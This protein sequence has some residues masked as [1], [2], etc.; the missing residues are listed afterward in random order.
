MHALETIAVHSGDDLRA[1]VRRA[2]EHYGHG[3]AQIEEQLAEMATPLYT[4]RPHA[5]LAQRNMVTM[6]RL[7]VDVSALTTEPSCVRSWYP[8]PSEEAQAPFAEQVISGYLP[9]LAPAFNNVRG[10]RFVDRVEA[11]QE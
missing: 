1:E 10:V 6:N 4:Y 8:T 11:E 5:L 9:M 7:G 3:P 2:S